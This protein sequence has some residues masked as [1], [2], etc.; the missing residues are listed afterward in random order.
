M[1]EQ[2]PKMLPVVKLAS[3]PIKLMSKITLRPTLA[4]KDPFCEYVRQQSKSAG[5]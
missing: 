4:K 1:D 5:S 3:P 2:K